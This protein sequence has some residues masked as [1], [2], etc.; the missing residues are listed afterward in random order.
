MIPI[1]TKRPA[2][3]L[4]R[5]RRQSRGHPGWKEALLSGWQG[6]FRKWLRCSKIVVMVSQLW[7]MLKT[8][9]LYT[10]SEWTIWYVIYITKLFLKSLRKVTMTYVSL[11]PINDTEPG[12]Q[13]ILNQP[14]WNQ[15]M[16]FPNDI[17]KGIPL[18]SR[19]AVKTVPAYSRLELLL[20]LFSYYNT[21]PKDEAHV[22]CLKSPLHLDSVML[23][24]WRQENQHICLRVV[25]CAPYRVPW[26]V[27]GP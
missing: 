13:Q 26:R 5:N 24:W 15:E 2:Q 3:Q 4:S 25:T 20:C 11:I 17:S 6:I 1:H 9:E 14:Q 23:C 21:P 10:L 22:F 7:N 16:S 12:L 27:E 8:S 18:H 19:T